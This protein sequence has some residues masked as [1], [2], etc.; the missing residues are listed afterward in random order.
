MNN[1]GISYP[2]CE[3]DE[4][5]VCVLYAPCDAQ[6]GEKIVEIY[7]SLGNAV[8]YDTTASSDM[9]WTDEIQRAI[10]N[11]DVAVLIY[12]SEAFYAC[13]FWQCYHFAR[14][15]KKPRLIFHL[16]KERMKVSAWECPKEIEQWVDP[17]DE[18]YEK[19]IDHR[20]IQSMR[21]KE[22]K[23][24]IKQPKYDLG[25][26]F[27][28][29]WNTPDRGEFFIN[30][31]THEMWDENRCALKT[32]SCE[33]LTLLRKNFMHA[34]RF[35]PKSFAADYCENE[36]DRNFIVQKKRE[37]ELKKKMEEEQEREAQLKASENKSSGG[38]PE[39]YPYM[40]EFE[41]LNSQ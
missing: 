16:E 28:P 38:F 19:T 10:A 1:S 6:V 31:R 7:Q 15:L 3:L 35:L 23:N 8:W 25:E 14:L 9:V 17:E 4:N 21:C 41:Y 13:Y 29:F 36:D 20:W 11:C 40:D 2:P 18:D 30:L 5:Y 22:S 24:V 39:G 32:V 34:C 33:E 26:H 12:S 37:E 27:S